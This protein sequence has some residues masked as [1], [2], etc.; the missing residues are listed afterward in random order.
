M[1]QGVVAINPVTISPK[2][3]ISAALAVLALIL[4]ALGAVLGRAE[5]G[6]G[7]GAADWAAIRFTVVQ[8]LWSA[9]LSVVLAV[10]VARRSRSTGF[11]G[12][13]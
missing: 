13:F 5:A 8:A 11:T 12:L 3:G 6:A 1:A 9:V 4:L 2:A 10:P 7:L